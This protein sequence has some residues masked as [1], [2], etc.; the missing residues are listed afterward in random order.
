MT[1]SP[2]H[3]PPRAGGLFISLLGAAQICSWGSLYY[4][5][6]LVA[7]AMTED[8]GW[9]K[10]ELYGAATLGLALA[11]LAA[12]PIG[13][14]IDSGRGRLIMTGGSLAA[15]ALLILWAY[16]GNMALFYLA[17]AGIGAMQAATLYD[18]AFAV[19]ARRAGPLHAR[20]GITAI[21]M[22][23]G[24][25][26]TV[27]IPLVHLLISHAGW[28]E[29]LLVLGL[30]NILICAALN[31]IAI[32][33]S[34]DAPTPTTAGHGATTREVMK[35]VL[36]QP[37]FWALAIAF[38]AYSAM[39]S[40]FTFHLYPL[41]IER[42]FDAA[43]VVSA[44]AVIGPAQVGGRLAIWLAVPHA[45]VRIVGSLIVAVF[46]VAFLALEFMP[47][48]FYGVAAFAVCFGA[49]NGIMTIVRGLV[50]P[51]LLTRRAYGAVNGALAIP[52]TAAR[53]VAPAGLALLW[54]AAG[55]YDAVLAAIIF[56]GLIL[57]AGF[58]SAALMSRR[59]AVPS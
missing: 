16:A 22:W 55:S 21:T 8:L 14:A 38:T 1:S 58:W 7:S 34:R 54:S 36:R 27:F 29:T 59:T 52:A 57:A 43:T 2:H 9:S 17:V 46:P 41:L 6:P 44:I 45:P 3:T 19:V 32:D 53:A 50:V 20:T 33:P 28:R 56:G 12:Y 40:G 49:A 4:A 15:G 30:I 10:T 23:G 5:F 47:P 39:F 11:G 25:A 51:E 48:S 35:Q 26:S 31:F 37:V 24:F 42:G 18:P 13:A